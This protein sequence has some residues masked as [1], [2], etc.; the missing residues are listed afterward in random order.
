VSSTDPKVHKT[1]AEEIITKTV[2]GFL[3]G[4]GGTL[5]VG[6]S[7]DGKPVG[8]DADYAHVQP[9]NADG[10]VNWLDTMLESTLGHGGAH[11]VQTRIDVVGGVEVCRLDVPASSKPIWTT[12]KKK[13][14]VLFERRNNSTR[15]VPANEIDAFIAE[16]FGLA[17]PNP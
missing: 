3:N 16:R 8:L 9:K 12:F 7:D 6:V 4:Q 10:F 17:P 5:L 11:R 2:A 1:L 15:E 13:E 14:A